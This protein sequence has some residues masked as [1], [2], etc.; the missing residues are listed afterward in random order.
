M[1]PAATILALYL[2]AFLLIERVAKAFHDHDQ[3]MK[4]M[5]PADSL[6]AVHEAEKAKA[7]A[8]TTCLRRGN[9]PGECRQ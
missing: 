4:S 1:K 9:A 6:R 2:G 8:F 7:V 5:Q 3:T